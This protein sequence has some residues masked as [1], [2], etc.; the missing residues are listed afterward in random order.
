MPK[1][2]SKNKYQN[3]YSKKGSRN[4]QNN[5]NNNN[6]LIQYPQLQRPFRMICKKGWI[7]ADEFRTCLP[8][9]TNVSLVSTTG[10]PGTY[11][12]RGNG[13]FDPDLTGTGAQPEGYDQ[14]SA[15]Y[16]NVRVLGS[17]ITVIP[18]NLSAS[19][20]WEEF[21]VAPLP[22][23]TAVNL[24]TGGG[25]DNIKSQRYAKDSVIQTNTFTKLVS[26]CSTAQIYGKSESAVEDDTDFGAPITAVPV[27]QWIWQLSQVAVDRTNTE[28]LTLIVKLEYDCVFFGRV[29]LQLS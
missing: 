24:T 15:F 21:V 4:S 14:F 8:F 22:G 20:S 29:G 25:L 3:K 13:P 19:L 23:T 11:L 12:F 7:I 17:R 10:I 6:Q 1:S 18:Q 16:S 28:T 26:A 2:Q 27:N 9:T 5:K